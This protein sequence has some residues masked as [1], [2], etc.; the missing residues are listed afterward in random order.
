MFYAVSAVFQ[1]HNGGTP[2]SKLTLL[3]KPRV[4][5]V[6]VLESNKHEHKF[7]KNIIIHLHVHSVSL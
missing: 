3:I 4:L 5:S 2:W 6:H 1:A 7:R